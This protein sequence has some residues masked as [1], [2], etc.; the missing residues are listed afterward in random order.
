[1]GF[2]LLSDETLDDLQLKG[3][4]IIQKKN[5]FRFGTDAVYCQACCQPHEI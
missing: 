2:T 4:F 3:L 1:M 5:T